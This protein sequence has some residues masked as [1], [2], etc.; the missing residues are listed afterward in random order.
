MSSIARFAAVSV[1]APS[2]PPVVAA[3]LRLVRAGNADGGCRF[4]PGSP[5]LA[6]KLARPVVGDRLIL[7]EKIEDVADGVCAPATAAW[8]VAARLT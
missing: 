7:C 5:Q 4:Y 2:T 8:T 1:D 3:Y 6:Q